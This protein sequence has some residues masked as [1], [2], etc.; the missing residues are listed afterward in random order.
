[1]DGSVALTVGGSRRRYGDTIGRRSTTREV[2]ARHGAESSPGVRRDL[3]LKIESDAS[4]ARRVPARVPARMRAFAPAA[5]PR[6]ESLGGIQ[7]AI[8]SSARPRRVLDGGAQPDK[9]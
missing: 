8:V 1:M 3:R 4:D 6:V 5:T 9:R 2:T 7:E